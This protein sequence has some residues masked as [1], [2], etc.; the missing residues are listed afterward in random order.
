MRS[1]WT[2]PLTSF[3]GNF[4]SGVNQYNGSTQYNYAAKH[5]PM[6]FFSDTNGGNDATP[7]NPL[8]TQYAPLQQLAVDLAN[9]TV[10]DYNWITPNQYNDMHTTLANGFQGLSGDPAKIRQGDEFLRQILP[11]IMASNAYQNHGAI[12]IWFD[13]SESDGVTGDNADDFNHTIAEIV[14]SDR[15]HPNVK[16][17]PYASPLNFTHSSDLRT[18]QQIFRVG[19]LLLDADNAIDLSDLFKP[20]VVPKKP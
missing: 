18:W 6:V 4:V 17:L 5:N 7:S 20:G 1:Q 11:V 19:P 10:A 15:A 9:D 8:S 3:Q 2:V 16:G 13:E 14:I 12:V